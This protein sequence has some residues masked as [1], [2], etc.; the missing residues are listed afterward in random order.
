MQIVREEI[1]GPVASVLSFD[2][3]DEVT[4]RANDTVFGLSAGVF[5][6]DL[7]RAHRMASNPSTNTT[8]AAAL[9][10]QPYHH[11]STCSPWPR[12]HTLA[13]LCGT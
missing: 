1:F 13:G 6:N 5:T 7:Q 11:R 12:A 10:S 2:T 4:R 8:Y 9:A 3:E